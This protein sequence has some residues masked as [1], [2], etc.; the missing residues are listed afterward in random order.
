MNIEKNVEGDLDDI[1]IE[2]AFDKAD[3]NHDGEL[4]KEEIIKYL[5]DK[6]CNNLNDND[7]TNNSQ[8]SSSSSVSA[9]PKESQSSSRSS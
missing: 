4:T 3:V 2:N 7:I 8:S 5:F 1:A 9:S 6:K